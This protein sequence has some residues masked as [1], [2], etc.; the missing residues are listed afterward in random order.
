MFKDYFKSI[1]N[2][3]KK[4]DFRITESHN[5]IS[6]KVTHINDKSAALVFHTSFVHCE[7]FF[8]YTSF[9]LVVHMSSVCFVCCLARPPKGV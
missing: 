4:S 1:K 6:F 7:A 3:G 5:S 2:V 8:G 9:T